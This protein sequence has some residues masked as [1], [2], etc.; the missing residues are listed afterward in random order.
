M[1]IRSHKA[2]SLCVSYPTSA[3]TIKANAEDDLS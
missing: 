1:M 3:C 2:L